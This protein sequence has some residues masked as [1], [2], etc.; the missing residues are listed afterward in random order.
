MTMEGV[1]RNTIALFHVILDAIEDEVGINGLG[2]F[3]NAKW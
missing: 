2:C 1:S 3:T